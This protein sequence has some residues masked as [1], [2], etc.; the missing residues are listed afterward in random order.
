[1]K[2]VGNI[3]MSQY[4]RSN[5]RRDKNHIF[6]V[7]KVIDD[8]YVLVVDGDVRRIENPK[9]KKCKHLF[10]YN[11][12]SEVVCEKIKDDKKITNLMIRKEIEKFDLNQIKVGGFST[13]Q[14]V[15]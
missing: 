11:Q 6:I 13:W 7:V 14:K 9:R 1:M 2:K 15:K 5:A 12:M 3:Q 8:E 4:V 10:D